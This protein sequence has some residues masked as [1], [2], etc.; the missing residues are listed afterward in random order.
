MQFKFDANQEYQIKAV[1][2][3]VNL[4]EGQQRISGASVFIGMGDNQTSLLPPEKQ[5]QYLIA[6]VLPGTIANTL[7]LT[8]DDLLANLNTIQRSNGIEPDSTLKFIEETIDTAAG[9][10]KVRFPNFS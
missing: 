4:L 5:G 7:N 6:E 10:K 3:A 2:A 8:E 1:E 9:Q